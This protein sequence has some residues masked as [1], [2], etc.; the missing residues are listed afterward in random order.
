MQVH[1]FNRRLKE[2]IAR[3]FFLLCWSI[4]LV[5]LVLYFYASLGHQIFGH[6]IEDVNAEYAQNP[7]I[8]T[9]VITFNSVGGSLMLV[10]QLLV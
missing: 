5:V 4:V 9:E 2:S 7:G 3:T 1:I 10:F 6:T 8:D